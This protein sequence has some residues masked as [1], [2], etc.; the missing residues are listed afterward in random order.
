MA[1]VGLEGVIFLRVTIAIAVLVVAQFSARD[2]SA[3]QTQS[4]AIDLFSPAMYSQDGDCPGGPNAPSRD[5]YPQRL[6]SVGYKPDEIE[7]MMAIWNMGDQYAGP[8]DNISTNRANINGH[9]VNAYAHPAAVADSHLKT[10]TGKFGYGFHLDPGESSDAF[11]D[12]DSHEGGINNQLVRAIGCISSLRGSNAGVSAFWGLIWGSARET[13]PAWLITITGENLLA[14]GPV[15]I[16]FDRAMEHLEFNS[17]GEAMQDVT[18]RADP[19][20]RSHHDFAGEIKGGVISI[21]NPGP[22]RL[23]EDPL[24]MPELRLFETHL[25]LTRNAGGRVSGLIGGY[26]P[27]KD[28]YF[29]VGDGGVAWEH[30]TVPDTP[31]LYYALKHL[32]DGYPDPKTGENSAISAAYHIEAVPVFVVAGTGADY[33]NASRR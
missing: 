12:P 13:S 28:F 20:P 7:K 19:D 9:W 30:E 21:T 16:T 32:A 8:V 10:V 4:F 24:C 27:W 22:L 14:D 33:D 3:L 29:V 25:R 5:F 15:T 6:A 17:S 1:I 2:A 23:L 26:Q 31:G 18:Y 11:E